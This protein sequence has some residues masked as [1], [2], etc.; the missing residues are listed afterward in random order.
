[1]GDVSFSK[2][3][4]EIENIMKKCENYHE[5]C[6]RKMQIKIILADIANQYK[7]KMEDKQYGD[8]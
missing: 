5:V 6:L 4:R 3:E 1:M 7:K 2:L 8:N